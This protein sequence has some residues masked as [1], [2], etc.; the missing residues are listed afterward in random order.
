MS[1]FAISY[2]TRKI[3]F[4]IN[5]KIVEIIKSNL[6]IFALIVTNDIYD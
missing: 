1:K 3:D 5:V 4:T 2:L 6:F